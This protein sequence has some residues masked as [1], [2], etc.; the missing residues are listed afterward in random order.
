M[1]SRTLP[2]QSCAHWRATNFSTLI[3]LSAQLLD[4]VLSLP[5]NGSIPFP[6][7]RSAPADADFSTNIVE[8]IIHSCLRAIE[9]PSDLPGRFANGT[10]L[11]EFL[12]FGG[13]LRGIRVAVGLGGSRVG[14][15]L[16]CT[17]GLPG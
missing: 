3:G 15:E 6:V 17:A 10:P 11:Q 13:D 2:S 8:V 7:L 5:P 9:D 4:E 14:L 16:V 12:L 1:A